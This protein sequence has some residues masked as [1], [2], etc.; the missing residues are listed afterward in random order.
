MTKLDFIIKC[1]AMITKEDTKM[2]QYYYNQLND[3]AK[4]CLELY[5]SAVTEAYLDKENSL[6]KL[7]EF[8]N[9][10]QYQGGNLEVLIESYLS[11]I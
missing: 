1:V 2:A 4:Q 7:E 5:S 11:R 9:K 3:I 6:L 8:C 10:S